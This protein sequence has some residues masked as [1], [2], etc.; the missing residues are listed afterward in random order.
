MYR[1]TGYAV[2]P[3][4]HRYVL[5]LQDDG[6]ARLVVGPAS[7]VAVRDPPRPLPTPDAR[8][9]AGLFDRSVRPAF[10]FT[11]ARGPDFW[12]W[13]YAGNVGFEYHR[14]GDDEAGA[15][16]A[17]VEPVHAC[18][19]PDVHGLRVLRLV[20]RPPST[21]AA[22]DGQADAP[23]TALLAGVLGWAAAR[24]CVAADFQCASSR[25]AHLLDPLGFRGRDRAQLAE[26]FAPF[27]PAA[28]PINFVWNVAGASPT[29][30][31]DCYVV[32]SDCD[33]DRPALWP[34]AEPRGIAC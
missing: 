31:D 26:L 17:R 2:L 6:F 1:T 34:T 4:L 15:A 21:A 32:K 16:V 8:T 9:L 13:R 11:Q 30:A 20:E 14:F 29:S 19:R 27:R 23:L 18:D 3:H 7:V 24:G 33:M 22:W 25:A 28:A 12:S 10:R 5:P